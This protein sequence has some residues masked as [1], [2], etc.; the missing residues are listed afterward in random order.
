MTW[1]LAYGAI[2]LLSL[3]VLGVLLLR[4]WRS[5][6]ALGRQVALAGEQ[7]AEVNEQIATVGQTRG[8]GATPRDL[9]G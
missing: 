1:A 8:R 4:V 2:G 7:V 5:I 3:L 9:P 6:K